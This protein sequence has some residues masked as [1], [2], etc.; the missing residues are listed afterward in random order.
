MN[1]APEKIYLN[2][3]IDKWYVDKRKEGDTEYIR[4]DLVDGLR[5]ALKDAVLHL[6][7]APFNYENEVTDSGI[8]EGEYYG[9]RAHSELVK[10]L[11][12]ALETEKHGVE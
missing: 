9:W 4:A 11:E 2:N 8:D 10:L 7:N 12:A 5:E 6:N 3:W 1:K